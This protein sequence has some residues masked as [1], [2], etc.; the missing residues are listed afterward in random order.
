M[1]SNDL[2]TADHATILFMLQ[3]AEKRLQAQHE[4]GIAR[5][6]RAY[7]VLSTATGLSAGAAAFAAINPESQPIFWGAC[8]FILINLAAMVVM[9]WAMRPLNVWVLGW[10]PGKL[11]E[12]V[13]DQRTLEDIQ[14]SVLVHLEHRLANND[15]IA[16]TTV[17]TVMVGMGLIILSLVCGPVVALLVALGG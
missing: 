6:Q 15:H 2:A 11:A 4:L 12:D 13:R 1:L 5:D 3:E 9:L 16:S 8:T 10:T 17:R 7:V 14:R